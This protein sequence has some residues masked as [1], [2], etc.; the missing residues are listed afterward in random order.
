MAALLVDDDIAPVALG[1]NVTG[2]FEGGFECGA[3]VGGG[4][5]RGDLLDA[6][7]LRKSGALL[8]LVFVLGQLLP[9]K[10]LLPLAVPLRVLA[11]DEIMP[12]LQLH[13]L[14]CLLVGD[15]VI[16][17]GYDFHLVHVGALPDDVKVR[18]VVFAGVEH[19]GAGLV[20]QAKLL[21]KDV[22]G[23]L[24]LLGRH[25]ACVMGFGIYL[26]MI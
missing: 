15:V 21:S 26:G 10:V 1:E 16:G 3:I 20:R 24:P 5:E 6:V 4:V 25:I 9:G 18:A 2:V 8:I 12:E 13:A 19:E 11:G 14:A 17:V 22:G 7:F 23:A